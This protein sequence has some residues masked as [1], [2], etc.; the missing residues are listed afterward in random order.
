M[1]KFKGWAIPGPRVPGGVEIESGPDGPETLDALSGHYKIFQYER[2]HRYSTDDILAA[3]YGSTHAPRAER[4]LDLGSG[5]GS[6]A[7][8]AAWRLPGAS[9]VTIEAQARSVRLARKSVRYNGL[10]SRMEIREADFRD[11]AA[12]APD[13]KFDL[14]LGSPPYFPAEAG[15]RSEHPQKDACRFELRGD[16]GD[17]CRVARAHLAPG[18]VFACVFPWEGLERVRSAVA[19]CGGV[20]VRL[21]RVRL[22]E[23]QP[24]EAPLLFTFLMMDA[25]HLPPDFGQGGAEASSSPFEDA[26]LLIRDRAGQVTPQYQRLKLSMGFR[27]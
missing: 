8:L 10:G 14:I 22:N 17:Y 25:E 15:I 4:V 1:D 12:L 24:L 21:C 6:V 20:I 18:G 26:P 13:E 23:S 5:I 19:V 9:L 7:M 2:G 16:V 11:P 27:P 3:W